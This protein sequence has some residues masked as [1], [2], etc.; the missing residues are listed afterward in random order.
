MIWPVI[1]ALW[2]HWRRHPIQLITLLTGLALATGLWSAVQAINAEARASYKRANAQLSFGQ[3]DRLYPANGSIPLSRYVTLR[4]N[5][6]QVAAVL[7]GTLRIPGQSYDV[8]GVDL[9]SY[10]NLPAIAEVS[11]TAGLAP[12]DALT[13]P[14]RLFMRPEAARN[15][16]TQDSWP[17]V[18]ETMSV[19]SKTI[20]TDIGVAERLLNKTGQ[21]S[22]L[23]VLPN[24]PLNR[25]SLTEIAPELRRVKAQA[26]DQSTRLTDS[27]HLNLTA[28]GLLSFAVGLFIVHGT[29]GL[30]F[31]QRRGMIRT[32]RAL[33]VP[34]HLLTRLLLAELLVFA[35]IG[36]AIGL[37][38]GYG[39][40]GILL[41]DVAATLRG[42]YGAPI[43]GALSLR[44]SWVA[45]GLGMA[46]CG[47][48]AASFQ[49]LWRLSQLPLLAAPGVHA[50]ATKG[51]DRPIQ[52][53]AGLG[54]ILVGIAIFLAFN[55]LIAGFIMLAG[56][57]MGTA[58]L[59]PWCLEQALRHGQSRAQSPLGEWIWADMRAQLPGLS[60]AMMALMLALAANIGVGT[61]VS[62]FRLTFIGWLDQRLASELYVTAKDDAQGVEIAAWLSTRSDAVLPI[63][64]S[65]T[66]YQDKP[67][68]VYGIVDDPTYRDN[69]PLI[70][71]TPQVWDK[72]SRGQGVLINEQLA[73]REQIWPGDRITILESWTLPIVGVYSDYGNPTAQAITSLPF[74]L[75]HLPS[76][77][78]QRFGVRIA[79]DKAPA[80][81]RELTSRFDLPD[82]AVV[83]QG[84]LKSRSM[85]VFNKTFVVTG[86][87]NVLTLGVAGFAILTSMLTMWA[88][89]LPQV[90]PVWALG[91]TRKQ[92][93]RLEVLRSLALAAMTTLLALPLGL[94]LAWVLLTVINVEAFGWRLPLYLF[95]ADWIM[96][97]LVALLAAGIA[98]I[99][100][101]LRL[102]RTPPAD[103]LKVFTNDR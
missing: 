16:R 60:L 43:E 91:I 19:P 8:L 93:A 81:A 80:L 90:A 9:L 64:S 97:G 73:R 29:V 49:A 30:A 14:G 94:V 4:R 62:S 50:W 48:L 36:G 5:G 3:L 61:M 66:Q 44:P 95:P 34:L 23:L 45:A 83:D 99:L 82:Q 46:I 100:P 41:P 24:Q 102:N 33:G 87:L 98:A 85:A 31:E 75:N 84:Q 89:R 67:L 92:L 76:L 53:I 42:L 6:W 22:Y 71:K 65:K 101:A 63:R 70:A 68:F 28:F 17:P 55:G 26:T 79:P 74:L 12:V 96:L 57:M 56:I 7:T 32:L 47:T 58:L 40:A 27:F 20:L 11:Q 72:V 77:P 1:S 35:V 59:L 10:P 37:G 69:W 39:I 86:A 38:L 2:S 18:I 15:L 25:A 52:A 13:A 103:L 88:Q 54:L 51:I 78:N 21:I